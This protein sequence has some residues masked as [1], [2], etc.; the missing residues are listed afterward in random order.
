MTVHDQK[1]KKAY[2]L[3][4]PLKPI[5]KYEYI[6][7]STKAIRENF[8]SQGPSQHRVMALKVYEMRTTPIPMIVNGFESRRQLRG[9][10]GG[11]PAS[12]SLFVL[13]KRDE[14]MRGGK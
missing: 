5:E 8:K 9:S 7:P 4:W 3:G 13:L 14:F 12:L 10:Q 2:T 1:N 11:P 6:W